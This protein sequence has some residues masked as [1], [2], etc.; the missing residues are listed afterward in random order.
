VES[1]PRRRLLSAVI[2]V[3]ALTALTVLSLWSVSTP[4][5]K[6]TDAPA[7][8]FSAARAFAH[9]D[10]IGTQVHVTG[11]SASDEVRDYLQTT[12]NG[13]GLN[14]RVQEA[15]GGTD[16]LGGTYVM[17]R[18]R[19]LIA[20]LPGT[21]PTGKLFLVA[22][23]DSVQVSYGANDDGAGVATLLETARIL[24]Q[25]PRPRND[26][27]FVFTDAEEACLCGAEAFVSQDEL[28]ADGGVV[29]NFEAR[30]SSGPV[31]MFETSR[32][33]ADLVGVYGDAVPHPVATSFAVEVYRILPND[34]DFTPFRES[35]KFTG[36]NSAYID[37]SAVYHSPED[38]PSYMDKGSLQMHGDNALALARSL[39]SADLGQL[40]KASP[41]DSSYF[42]FLGFLVRYPGWLVW[43]LAGLALLSVVG[44]AVIARRRGLTTYG[45]SGLGF[46]SAFVPLLL[47]VVGA[48]GLWTVLTLIRP[49]YAVMLDPWHPG[50]FRLAV[51]G[52]ATAI[53]LAWFGVLR[54][55]LGAWG[56]MI[57]SF[58]LL[59]ALG[60]VLAT[61][62]PG[63]S[64]LAAIPTLFVAVGC[65]VGLMAGR[66]LRVLAPAVG[67]AAAIPVLAPTISLFFPALGLATGAAAAIFTVLLA[68]AA[69]PVL[70]GLYPETGDATASPQTSNKTAS[71]HASDKTASPHASDKTAP[72]QTSDK[73]ASPHASDKTASPQA[74]DETAS[75]G[76][77]DDTV[78]SR[79]KRH[80]LRSAAP[81]LV[82][83]ALAAVCLATGLGV[84]QFD[85]V[86][87]KPT[88]LMY[89][90]DTDTNAAYWLSE[91]TN[92]TPWTSQYLTGHEDLSARFPLLA[93]AGEG[94][95]TGPAQP[96][97][98]AAPQLTLESESQAGGAR[99]VTLR[100]LPQR[101]VRMVYLSVA[102]G[103]MV[104]QATVSGRALPDTAVSQA[105]SDAEG[106]GIL[107]HAP[108]PD[109]VRIT[110]VLNATGP[111]DFRAM[112]GSDGLTGLPGYN[113]RPADVGV[114]GSHQSELVLVAKSYR[115]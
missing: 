25:G 62:T 66:W 96:A 41:E 52:L 69:L 54:R 93:A 113:G 47:A 115:L 27:V 22:H 98:L 107:F 31:V 90:L 82:T 11:S 78:P 84:D 67:I 14:A 59:A 1:N 61:F 32:G 8:E 87:P 80:R 42:P 12:L 103:I 77:G 26:V 72:P 30:G 57:G 50:W 48:Q 33:N 83:A 43:P 45:R 16:K 86:H 91:E 63:G 88:Q 89:A 64:Y 102:K 92:P 51:V 20:V 49:S 19:N 13:Y 28:A 75:P 97:T 3:I 110:L 35:G 5:A 71:P 58:G 85:A 106:F 23:Y 108:G 4:A 10:H 34:T 112:D 17:A 37:G 15:V 68:F 7:D 74:I 29:L 53:V 40:S 21:D 76:R 81:G 100:L 79:P 99:T 95:S 94:F 9:V 46:A 101:T 38:R 105:G 111:V 114:D 2:A 6:G 18:V 70:D 65:T 55:R 109:G 104:T 36:L 60:I 56:L 24:S 44:L 39:G 73:T